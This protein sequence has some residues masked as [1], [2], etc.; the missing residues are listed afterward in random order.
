[1]KDRISISFVY[2]FALLTIAKC[3]L[4]FVLLGQPIAL[5]NNVRMSVSS[6][7]KHPAIKISIVDRT[8][9]KYP[10]VSSIF[11]TA[12]NRFHNFDISQVTNKLFRFDTLHD[13]KIC[14]PKWML[15][16]IKSKSLDST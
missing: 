4:G 9:R 14:R 6:F 1:M 11:A 12:L 8:F 10:S 2:A 3:G 16:S 5:S 7:V 15:C 13:F